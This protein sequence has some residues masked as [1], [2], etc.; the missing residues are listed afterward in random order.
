MPRRR[1][2]ATKISPSRRLLGGIEGAVD[3]L[4]APGVVGERAVLLREREA[5]STTCA[6]STSG[7]LVRGDEHQRLEPR[8]QVG[9]RPPRASQHVGTG[10]VEAADRARGD[11][12]TDRGRGR[13]R[14]PQA[15]VAGAAARSPPSRLDQKVVGGADPDRDVVLRAAETAAITLRAAEEL[16]VG[17]VRRDDGRE[18]I[19]TVTARARRR[20]DASGLR[21]SASS[22]T[23][24][25][26][27]SRR[28]RSSGSRRRSLLH[29]AIAQP[30][31]VAHPGV[32]HV[33]RCGA[34]GGARP[35]RR[36][37]PILTLQPFAQLGQTLSVSSRNQTRS[38]WWKSLLKSAPTGQMSAV[39]I[40]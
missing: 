15:E 34:A 8:A 16:L 6:R 31:V 9:S 28:E 21:R 4:H 35:R 3:A 25:P 11:A 1:P 12:V 22:Q 18:R 29:E 36:A 33:R 7:L 37:M 40:E 23:P 13:R 32:V 5:G 26:R 24:P 19:G 17:E 39:Q 27:R 14:R 20:A 30:P 38:L 2:S 10:H